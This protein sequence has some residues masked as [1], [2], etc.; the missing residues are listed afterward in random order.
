M[1]TVPHWLAAPAPIGR[2]A[3][4]LIEAVSPDPAG[5]ERRM[6]RVSG[7]EREPICASM[8]WN[9]L[10]MRSVRTPGLA[11]GKAGAAFASAT[12]RDGRLGRRSVR[13]VGELA[14]AV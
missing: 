13:L 14:G 12:T 2:L 10:R 9:R 7:E 11:A 3:P 5:D 8:A 4:S 1:R 6:L